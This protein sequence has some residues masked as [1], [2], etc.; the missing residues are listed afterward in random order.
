MQLNYKET[1]RGEFE[2]CT[3]EVRLPKLMKSNDEDGLQ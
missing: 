3:K 1:M 2:D